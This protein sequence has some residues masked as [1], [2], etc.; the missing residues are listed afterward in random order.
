[1]ARVLVVDD[2]PDILPPGGVTL[3]LAGHD[4]LLA[5][6]GPSALEAVRGERPD[7]VVLDVMLPGMDGWEILR[8]IKSD[9]DRGV[10]HVPVLLL[11]ARAGDLDR[12]RGGIEGAIGYVTKPFAIAELRAAVNDALEGDPEPVQRRHAQHAALERLARVE[13]G[14]GGIAVEASTR[15]R[16]RLTRFEAPPV[17]TPVRPPNGGGRSVSALSVKQVALLAAVSR[18]RTVRDAARELEVSRSNV[19]ASLRRIARKLDVQSVPAL[20]TLARDGGF[21]L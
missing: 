4:V 20:V 3:E 17:L 12:V 10:S 9:A 16:P 15:P 13:K 5:A 19:Y 11:T 18:T 21:E 8:R 2:E 6:D 1:M 7:L 14:R